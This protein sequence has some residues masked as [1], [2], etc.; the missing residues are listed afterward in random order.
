MWF[1]AHL[2]QV[3]RFACPSR[4]M[5]RHFAEW[6]LPAEKIAHVPN[7]Q[8]RYGSAQPKAVR[9]AHRN[10]FGYFGQMHDT[11]GVHIILR[12]VRILRARGFTDFR[13]DLN[14]AN[15]HFATPAM[16]TEVE[17]FLA[18]EA[19]LPAD[20]QIVFDNGSYHVDQLT[21]RMGRVDWCIVP[22]VWW[23]IFGLVISEAWM[24]GK[25]VIC[26][27]VGG[28]KERVADGVDGLHFGMGDPQ[29]LAACI[30]RAATEEGLWQSL[31]DNLPEPPARDAMGD[32]YL[33]LYAEAGM[34]RVT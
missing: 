9:P 29:A 7:G 31:H 4:F 15:I 2:E 28:M 6:G 27:D 32:N 25:P 14:G 20:Q 19:M 23:E 12:A 16:R 18:A 5:I 34:E 13:V 33:R 17:T 1:M 11:K 21:A 10:R 22:S 26:S 3:D 30:H 24:F 8:R